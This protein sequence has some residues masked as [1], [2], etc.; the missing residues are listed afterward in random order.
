MIMCAD[1]YQ[2]TPYGFRFHE[3]IFFS[4]EGKKGRWS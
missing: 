3:G 1:R 2:L 4:G